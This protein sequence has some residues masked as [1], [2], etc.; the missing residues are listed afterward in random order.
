MANPGSRE[1]VSSAPLTEGPVA[2]HLARLTGPMALG[3]LSIMTVGLADA[4]F[5]ARLGKEPLAALGFIYPVIV[6]L[7]SLGIG[8]SA[9]VNSVVSRTLG[10]G[11]EDRARRF[12]AHAVILAG[13]FGLVV[14]AIGLLASRQLFVALQAE[15]SVL[16]L[17]LAYMVIWL[18]SFPILIVTMCANAVLRG[19]GDTL[20]PAVVMGLTA[21]INIALDPVLIFG[22]GPL[23]GLGIAGAAWATIVARVF[24]LL[25]ALSLVLHFKPCFGLGDVKLAGLRRSVADIASIGAPAAF[26]NAINPAG[27]AAVTAIVAQF[28]DAA[29]AGFGAAGRIQSFVLMPLLALSGSIGPLVGQNWGAEKYER[30]ARAFGVASWACVAYGIALALV[31]VAWNREIAALFAVSGDVGR[32]TALYLGIVPCTLFGYGILIV[33]NGAMNASGK[34]LPLM[35]INVSRMAVLYIPLAALGAL[36]WDEAG[37]FIA[38]ATANLAAGGLALWVARRYGLARAA[39]FA[40]RLLQAR[41]SPT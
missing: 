27:M 30:A 11:K 36:V 21:A 9:G 35:M 26:S 19:H 12:S 13:A 28:G 29:V 17:V 39:E 38:A 23:P 33:G 7:T 31:L 1:R 41:G 32:V 4:F 16:Q 24:G 25:L 10:G 5:L 18:A 22:F 40:P 8:L 3:V 15:G 20:W 2:A 37:V 6:A 34:P 14:C